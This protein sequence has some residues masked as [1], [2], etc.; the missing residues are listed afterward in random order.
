MVR[1]SKREKQAEGG[2]ER[3]IRKKEFI[4]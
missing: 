2:R 4:D 1:E 3:K